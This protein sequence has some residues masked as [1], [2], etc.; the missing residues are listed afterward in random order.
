[1]MGVLCESN[2]PIIQSNRYVFVSHEMIIIIDDDDI[3]DGDNIIIIF[4][5]QKL[6]IHRYRV[7]EAVKIR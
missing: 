7:G 5:P 6:H 2:V 3:V 4:G 1:M